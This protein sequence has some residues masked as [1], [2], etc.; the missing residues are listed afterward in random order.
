MPESVTRHTNFKS[1]IEWLFFLYPLSLAVN[2]SADD[3]VA[4]LLFL[5]SCLFLV[6]ERRAC[7]S[8]V[9]AARRLW[10]LALMMPLL[11]VAVQGVALRPPLALRDFDDYSRFFFCIPVYL[12]ALALRLDTRKFLWGC[13]FF[14][15]YS[16][17][18]MV[19]QMWVIGTGRAEP[20]NGFLEII[21]HTSFAIILS[22]AGLRLAATGQGFLVRRL[23]PGAAIASALVMP[24]LAQ[25]RSGFLLLLA[26]W[27]LV[28]ILQPQRRLKTLACIA[29]VALA[30]VVLVTASHTLWTRGDRTLAEI[31]GYATAT[32]PVP[33]TSATTRIELWRL[34][35]RIA[36]SHP[37]IGIGNHRFR[38]GL[39]EMKAKHLTSPDLDTYSHPH[40][41]FLKMA[42]EGGLLGAL[43]FVLLLGVPLVSGS[44]AYQRIRG[45]GDPAWM[46][47]VFASGVL[48][49]GMVDV[50]LI[51]R[52]TVMFYGMSMSLLLA[53]LGRCTGPET[54]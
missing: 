8:A 28:W 48:I 45:I 31:S 32:T 43:A 22:L 40:N 11:L 23:V 53:S 51:W 42:A 16:V 5:T 17:P 20:P 9:R 34:A 19:Y 36:L 12:A 44:R 39:V 54:A 2:K 26:M 7:I 27:L 29:A 47:I 15:L 1:I 25:T 6:I 4:A 3:V 24:V 14:T 37:L 13:L 41:D 21:P 10:V 35:G 30:M 18:L 46:V 49:A 38:A 33:L 52:P 50:V